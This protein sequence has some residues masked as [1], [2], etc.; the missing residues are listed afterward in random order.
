MRNPL[1]LFFL[2]LILHLGQ[3]QTLIQA[4][5]YFKKNRAELSRGART[6]LDDLAR[7]ILDRS[8]SHILVKGYTDSYADSLYNAGL[9]QKRCEAVKQYLVQRGVDSTRIVF[10]A[11]GEEF[12][13]ADN[14][15]EA[16]RSRNRRVDVF[17]DQDP[18]KT[19]APEIPQV[20][21]PCKRDTLL[22]LR[23]G[24]I[25]S[26]NKC[27]FEESPNCL[28]VTLG[29]YEQN[30][31][32]FSKF[33]MKM[34]LKNHY[35][36]KDRSVF[37]KVNVSC[38]DTGCFG[39]DVRLYVPVYQVSEKKFYV[40]I[41]DSAGGR[42]KKYTE[43]RIKNLKR[44][45]Y[46]TFTLRC[47]PV[48]C[49]SCAGGGGMDFLIGCGDP[50]KY[51][52]CR[53]SRLKLKNGLKAYDPNVDDYFRVRYFAAEHGIGGLKLMNDTQAVVINTV[54][55]SILRHGLRH[56]RNCSID[57]WF[58]FIKYHPRC[59]TYRKYKF[60]RR[61]IRIQQEKPWEKTG[62]REGPKK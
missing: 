7:E 25:V 58:L 15:N 2:L 30:R 49:K 53:Q 42:W 4:S 59:E 21:D 22:E 47:S 46:S 26:V 48:R 45:S 50:T 40:S 52:S 12:P 54:E 29:R 62:E 39:R 11:Y 8:P 60:G 41:Y 51:C 9:S 10:Y 57:K 56:Q 35:A 14:S 1:L 33:R 32:K 38:A 20:S 34:G 27:R 6:T 23:Y 28:Q 5:V 61:D 37:Y 19:P 17:V 43:P 16:G 31:I 55:M 24:V 44:K 36:L 13:L 3:A 18:P